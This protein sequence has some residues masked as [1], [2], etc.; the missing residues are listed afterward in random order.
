M[1]IHLNFGVLWGQLY[2]KA[3]GRQREMTTVIALFCPRNKQACQM[4]IRDK[5]LQE[6]NS[7][8]PAKLTK[9]F[10]AKHFGIFKVP[11]SGNLGNVDVATSFIR[12]KMEDGR[13]EFD[14]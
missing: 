10:S 5:V 6:Q 1:S 8:K 4:P 3:I 7:N 2:D 13:I 12:L 11:I 14:S 9:T